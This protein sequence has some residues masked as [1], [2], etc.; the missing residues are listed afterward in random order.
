MGLPSLKEQRKERI[1]SRTD[2]IFREL[3]RVLGPKSDQDA[4]HIATAE[5]HNCYCFLTMDFKLIRSM[6]AQ[7]RN[8]TIAALRT[9]VISPE[10]FGKEFGIKEFMPRLLSYHEASYPV[11]HDTNW[12]DSK[13]KSRKK[14]KR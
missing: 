5:M 10:D 7:S 14:P 6:Q 1:L 13:R 12:Q 8:P 4:W 11:V 3:L 2:P 9:K